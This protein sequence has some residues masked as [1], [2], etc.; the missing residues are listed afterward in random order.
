MQKHSKKTRCAILSPLR[1]NRKWCAKTSCA[2]AF[3]RD[4]GAQYCA[5]SF[6]PLVVGK[7]LLP[8]VHTRL[9]PSRL[10]IT[11][12]PFSLHVKRLLKQYPEFH[13]I[14]CT[15]IKHTQQG[16]HLRHF[17]RNFNVLFGVSDTPVRPPLG[18]MRKALAKKQTQSSRN[19][20]I[21]GTLW[22]SVKDSPPAYRWAKGSKH[23]K[24]LALMQTVA[25]H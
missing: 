14:Y 2:L 6:I 3:D 16:Q 18:K 10:S 22:Y 21:S 9:L 7:S 15:T 5:W 13:H 11:N 4:R 12:I 19:H 17:A 23:Q 8:S 24:G 1:G 20:M 25:S